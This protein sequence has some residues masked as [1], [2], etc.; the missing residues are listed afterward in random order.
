MTKVVLVNGIGAAMA[1]HFA[2]G[3]ARTDRARLWRHRGNLQ[4]RRDLARPAEIAEG[5]E[6]VEKGSTGEAWIPQAGRPPARAEFPLIEL[7]P[8]RQPPGPAG[9]GQCASTRWPASKLRRAAPSAAATV[10]SK[11]SSSLCPADLSPAMSASVI[12]YDAS[13]TLST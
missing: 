11:I 4:H 12:W 8:N 7:S 13:R 3:G 1:R 6:W 10:S 2:R 5:V 9:Q